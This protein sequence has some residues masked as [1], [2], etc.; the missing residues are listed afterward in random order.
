M[1][2]AAQSLSAFIGDAVTRGESA[3]ADDD[4]I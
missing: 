1:N 4:A 2:R 3:T